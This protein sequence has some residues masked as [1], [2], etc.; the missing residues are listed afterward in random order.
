MYRSFQNACLVVGAPPP[1]MRALV[2]AMAAI[3]ERKPGTWIE[4]AHVQRYVETHHN[5]T[6]SAVS[7]QTELLLGS[8]TD[9]GVLSRVPRM[10]AA[11][12]YGAKPFTASDLDRLL[13]SRTTR[14]AAI[15]DDG[16]YGYCLHFSRTRGKYVCIDPHAATGEGVVCELKSLHEFL[17][18][19]V[20]WMV[21]VVERR[22]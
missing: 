17:S 19:A 8:T 10:S 12:D 21:A 1:E 9:V 20:G 6:T 18:R 2:P 11:S 4:P 16:V 14:R 7:L 3:V 15:M 5:A 13:R 22:R